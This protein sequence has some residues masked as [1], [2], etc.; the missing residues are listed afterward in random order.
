MNVWP[1]HNKYSWRWISGGELATVNILANNVFFLFYNFVWYCYTCLFFSKR[2]ISLKLNRLQRCL[3]VL[4]FCFDMFW[5]KGFYLCNPDFFNTER[6]NAQFPVRTTLINKHITPTIYIY[7]L[8]ALCIG[9]TWGFES[10]PSSLQVTHDI[11][12]LK[13][14]HH[15]RYLQSLFLLLWISYQVH[16]LC[17][18]SVSKSWKLFIEDLL[19]RRI[20]PTE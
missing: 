15:L 20:K 4:L 18:N 5:N 10:I 2:Q 1:G 7:C 8:I 12:E 6:C 19:I 13:S 17:L 9:F 14:Y 16:W 3:N 11:Q